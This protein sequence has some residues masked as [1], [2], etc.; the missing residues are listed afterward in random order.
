M[1]RI[2]LAMLGMV[3][4]CITGCNAGSASKVS[5]PQTNTN[6][7]KAS[8]EPSSAP[9]ATNLK[10]GDECSTQFVGKVKMLSEYEIATALTKAEDYLICALPPGEVNPLKEPKSQ[11]IVQGASDYYGFSESV[12]KKDNKV[13]ICPENLDSLVTYYAHPPTGFSKQLNPKEYGLL[14][15][16]EKKLLGAFTFNPAGSNITSKGCLEPVDLKKFS[17]T[18]DNPR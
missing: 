16:K 2:T 8:I 7:L 14:F 18:P 6:T 5:D 9:V 12:S 1:R 17:R 13:Y 15:D 11:P 4:L 3:I 10:P